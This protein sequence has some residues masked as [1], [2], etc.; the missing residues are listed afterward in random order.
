[1]PWGKKK[2]RQAKEQRLKAQIEASTPQVFEYMDRLEAEGWDWSAEHDDAR[3]GPKDI[4][5]FVADLLGM[6]GDS[7]DVV[8][9]TT[10]E[11]FRIIDERWGDAEGEEGDRGTQAA[12]LY[13]AI[14]LT[15][16]GNL[17]GYIP[18]SAPSFDP[19][20]AAEGRRR[21]WRK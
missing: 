5:G 18:E 2:T 14:G 12:G 4:A 13:V 1:V 3:F 21:G 7:I 10:G 20:L 15:G 16:I 17:Y 19:E 9:E 11:W 6:C 8:L